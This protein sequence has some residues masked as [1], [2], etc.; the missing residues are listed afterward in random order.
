[1]DIDC[2]NLVPIIGSITGLVSVIW[3]FVDKHG[4]RKYQISKDTYQKIFDRKLLVYRDLND[5]LF[6]YN[7][8]LTSMKDLKEDDSYK[9]EMETLEK[10]F[11]I[12]K[13]YFFILSPKIE[14]HY[15]KLD[16]AYKATIYSFHKNYG[17]P[18]LPLYEHDMKEDF[19]DKNRQN[20]KNFFQTIE[21]VIEIE[22]ENI[23][24]H[25]V[26]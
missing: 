18:D 16:K 6:D 22:R 8:K 19:Y 26:K 25:L 20:I 15:K 12:M 24:K 5:T 13:K 23:N 11:E 21:D 10:V 7:Q 1:M 4:D 3:T 14:S 9:L 17:I 2:K